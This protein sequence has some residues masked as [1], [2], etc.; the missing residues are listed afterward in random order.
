M[1]EGTIRSID[2]SERSVVVEMRDG[3]QVT[4]QFNSNAHIEVSEPCSGGTQGGTL[5]DLGVGYIVQ[6]DYHEDATCN[7]WRC[8][9]LISIS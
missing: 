3:N 8:T 9:N 5:Q 4:L 2:H 7:A 6:V 1:V